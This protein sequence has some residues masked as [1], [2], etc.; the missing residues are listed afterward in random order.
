MIIALD[1]YSGTGKSTLSKLI[2]NKLNF[3]YLNTGMI[4]RAITYY[5]IKN[6]VLPEDITSINMMTA[7]L[8]VD[9]FYKNNIQY[10]VVN[11]FNCSD[12]VSDIIVQNNVSKFSQIKSIRQKV[13][14]I[15]IAISKTNNIV[16]EGRD[17]GT[18]V[19]PNA[20]FKFFVVCDVKVR[21]KRRYDD[22][23]N[24]NKLTTLDEVEKSIIERDIMDTTRA[25]SPLRKAEDAII[26]DTSTKSIEE[27]LNEI[28]SYIKI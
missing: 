18:E 24:S 13:H 6:N 2:A 11:N 25:I 20:E 21:A 9:V 28:L 4:Y 16:V 23:I 27:S 3:N 15:Q 5:F 12:F 19:F 8:D 22:L 14:N 26:I 7:T 1:G 10:V 17:I